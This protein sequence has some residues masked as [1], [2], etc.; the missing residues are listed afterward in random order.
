M[1]TKIDFLRDEFE[2]IGCTPPKNP[3]EPRLYVGWHYTEILVSGLYE[4]LFDYDVMT[5]ILAQVPTDSG[6]Q[7]FWQRVH[8]TNI[9]VLID[10]LNR[11]QPFAIVN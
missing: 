1:A 2:R 3:F 4:E 10:R 9:K 7:T 5:T 11:R 6:E 8:G